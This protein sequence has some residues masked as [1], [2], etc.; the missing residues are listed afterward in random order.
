MCISSYSWMRGLRLA[1]RDEICEISV[2]RVRVCVIPLTVACMFPPQYKHVWKSNCGRFMRNLWLV[3]SGNLPLPFTCKSVWRFAHLQHVSSPEEKCSNVWS[4][5]KVD[6]YHKFRF[7]QS[8][9]VPTFNWHLSAALF[10]VRVFAYMYFGVFLLR[11]YWIYNMLVWYANNLEQQRFKLRRR[12]DRVSYTKARW[13]NQCFPLRID[14]QTMM[15]STVIAIKT[16]S[17]VRL[18]AIMVFRAD[19]RSLNN[20]PSIV[21]PSMRSFVLDPPDSQKPLHVIPHRWDGTWSDF[22]NQI[23]EDRI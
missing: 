15:Y 19:L 13:E 10:C 1:M 17:H 8:C 23:H 16:K 12:V 5:F 22:P 9:N 4:C 18:C 2:G 20:T 6:A 14:L 11:W 7:G 21:Q 3:V